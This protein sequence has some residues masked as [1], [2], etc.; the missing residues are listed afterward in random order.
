MTQDTRKKIKLSNIGVTVTCL[1][2]MFEIIERTRDQNF[3]E[4]RRVSL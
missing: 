4:A 3:L 1:A 2:H